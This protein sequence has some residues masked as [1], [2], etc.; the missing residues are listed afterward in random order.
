MGGKIKSNSNAK[1]KYKGK[2]RVFAKL[3]IID[4][5]FSFSRS[6]HTAAQAALMG[7]S[8]YLR[9]SQ[10]CSAVC[11]RTTSSSRPTTATNMP[12]HC[13][14]RIILT[15]YR[16]AQAALQTEALVP[17][18]ATASTLCLAKR[19]ANNLFMV[20]TTAA[21]Y[22]PQTASIH[23]VAEWLHNSRDPATVGQISASKTLY[24]IITYLFRLPNHFLFLIAADA[25]QLEKTQTSGSWRSGITGHAIKEHNSASPS[26]TPLLPPQAYLS[27]E[28]Q[29]GEEG[30]EENIVY[31]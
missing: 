14:R 6:P 5:V 17:A 16:S 12:S 4:F 21:P 2:T 23:S 19:T 3:D 28:G 24:K 20:P 18:S 1:T 31:L 22:R 13:K 8:R 15:A 25:T 30:V 26:L 29:N 10:V 7:T 9:T 11:N 27:L